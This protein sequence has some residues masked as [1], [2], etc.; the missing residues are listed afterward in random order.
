MKSFSQVNSTGLFP[1]VLR[2][3]GRLSLGLLSLLFMHG[4][5][6][7]AQVEGPRQISVDAI[8]LIQV[9]MPPLHYRDSDGAYQLFKVSFRSRGERNKLPK[10][11]Q[12]TLYREALDEDN[13]T[14]MVP[15]FEIPVRGVEDG[16]ILFFF[17]N[18]EGK[19]QF[20]LIDD[21]LDN[22]HT[23]LSARIVN[24][25][26]SVVVCKVGDSVVQ[27]GP[28]EDKYAEV[29]TSED[30][31]FRFGFAMQEVDGY[32]K[33][34]PVKTLKFPT[35]TTRFLSAITY[36]AFSKVAADGAE[37]HVLAP[38]SLRLYDQEVSNW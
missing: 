34:A 22:P 27:L 25:T 12:I 17:A 31:R 2:L 15:I 35:E 8:Q 14:I 33:Y 11:N 6:G 1:R 24:L 32:Q 36:T 7:Q 9:N 30:K 19:V 28:N 16:A 21:S 10:G 37:G 26:D 4:L 38:T 29:K 18:Q 5:M 20:R 3:R 13:K 23:A